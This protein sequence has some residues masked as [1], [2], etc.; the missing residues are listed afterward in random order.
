[1]ALPTKTDV[2][3]LDWTFLGQSFCDVE[4]KS[5]DTKLLDFTYLGQ[6]FVVSAVS[7]GSGTEVS[8]IKGSVA[9]SGKIPSISYAL[10]LAPSRGSITVSGKIPSISLVLSVSTA[11]GSVSLSGKAPSVSDSMK[12]CRGCSPTSLLDN[13]HSPSGTGSLPSS[14]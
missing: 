8:P 6:P 3:L 7:G 1:M 12:R 10:S 5:L 2:L 14:L 4:A 13:S 11:K 9:L